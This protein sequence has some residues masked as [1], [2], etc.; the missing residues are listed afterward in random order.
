MGI[1]WS[2]VTNPIG[3]KVPTFGAGNN[4]P[5]NRIAK[6]LIQVSAIVPAI[7]RV[8]HPATLGGTF[9]ATT[10]LSVVSGKNEA[11]IEGRVTSFTDT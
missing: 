6:L 7:R 4:P 11:S 9:A 2:R 3:A 8:I 1:E 10:A 5:P